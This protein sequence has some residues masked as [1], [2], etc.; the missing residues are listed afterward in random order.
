MKKNFGGQEFNV[1]EDKV[2]FKLKELFYSAGHKLNWKNHKPEGVGINKRALA[3]AGNEKKKV[4]ITLN[5]KKYVIDGFKACMRALRNFSLWKA[6]DQEV[7]VIP[8]DMFEEKK[9]NL[10]EYM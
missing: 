7:L 9:D 2:S 10:E 3:Y 8:F 4:V 6:G 5:D 1:T